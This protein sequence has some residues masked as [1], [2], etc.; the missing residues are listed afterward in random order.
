MRFD[1]NFLPARYGDCIWIEYGTNNK[2]HRILI[3]GG[4]SGTKADIKEL[5][6]ALPVKRASF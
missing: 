3:D 5:I 4:T 6:E 1:I 2:T